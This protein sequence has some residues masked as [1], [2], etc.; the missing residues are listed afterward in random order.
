MFRSERNLEFTP[1]SSG[2]DLFY[3]GCFAP[4]CIESFE[5]RPSERGVNCKRGWIDKLPAL[6][7]TQGQI[8]VFFGQLPCKCYQNRVAS[9]GD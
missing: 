1:G 3:P 8:D 9:V 2:F 6:E 5:P 7:A 4:P